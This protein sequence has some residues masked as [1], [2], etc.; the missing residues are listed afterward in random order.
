MNRN[1]IE[2]GNKGVEISR[3]PLEHEICHKA[4]KYFEMPSCLI[5]S[6]I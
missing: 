1:S 3:L 5:V 4:N 2:I 6:Q